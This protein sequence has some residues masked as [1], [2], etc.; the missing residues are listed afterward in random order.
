MTTFVLLLVLAGICG[1]A[2]HLLFGRGIA[3]IPFYLLAS[4]GGAVVG[5]TISMLTNLKFMMVGGLPV[6]L[7]AGGSLLFLALVH[8]IRLA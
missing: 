1:F 7:T 4:L 6:L 2:F 5:F 8:R 3:S